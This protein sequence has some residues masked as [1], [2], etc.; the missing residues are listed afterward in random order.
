MW[1]STQRNIMQQVKYF[2]SMPEQ[3]IIYNKL[4]F[5]ET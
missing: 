3:E 5:K 4:M 1:R 2:E